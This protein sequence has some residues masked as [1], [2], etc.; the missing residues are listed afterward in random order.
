MNENDQKYLLQESL[1]EEIFS[2]NIH[3][4]KLLTDEVHHMPS[5]LEYEIPPRYFMDM[6]VFLPVNLE[7]SFVYWEVTRKLLSEYNTTAD[8]LKIK[9]FSRDG[10]EERE[11]VEFSVN[12]ELGKYYLHVKAPMTQMQARM[13]FTNENGE[14]IVIL[15]SNRFGTPNDRIEF[16]EDELWMSVDE[17]TREILQASLQKNVGNIS[18]LE[19][20]K[21]KNMHLTTLRGFSS[22][23]LIKRGQ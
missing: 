22:G 15:A 1:K 14:F 17:N 19:L 21:E 2:S 3:S 5:G 13:G 9:V 6:L 20:L 18:S 8:N 23:D 16:C 4:T 10:K 7:T 11:L 12:T